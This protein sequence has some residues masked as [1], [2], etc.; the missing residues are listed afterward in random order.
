MPL[1]KPS[2]KLCRATIN[3]EVADINDITMLLK[4]NKLKFVLYDCRSSFCGCFAF[5]AWRSSVDKIPK[6]QINMKRANAEGDIVG[7]DQLS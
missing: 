6:A 3:K 1:N 2:K 7:H 4:R 5:G